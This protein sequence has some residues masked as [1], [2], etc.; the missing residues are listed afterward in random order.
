MDDPLAVG[1]LLFV[2]LS[3]DL[4]RVE[5]VKLVGLKLEA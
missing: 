5:E 3:L 2:Q 1:V 4:L